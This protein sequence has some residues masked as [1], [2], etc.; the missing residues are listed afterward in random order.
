MSK[1][2]GKPFVS[3]DPRHRP[4]PGSNGQLRRDMT[5]ELI[6]QLN[7]F[8]TEYCSPK[9]R[10]KLHRLIENLLLHALG[11]DYQDE[12]GNWKRDK[13]DLSAI[14]AVIDRLEGRAPRRSRSPATA[15]SR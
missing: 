1:P 7:E 2:R 6:S 4:G 8:N 12:K 14:L 5:I 15:Q 9:E 3:G 13:G 10:I 11:T